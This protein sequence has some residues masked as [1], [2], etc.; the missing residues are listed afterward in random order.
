VEKPLPIP[1]F[2]KNRNV[3]RWSI[4]LV[5]VLIGFGSIV[6]SN[7]L[8]EKLKER[9]KKYVDLF[10]KTLEFT[11]NDISGT[12]LTFL[13]EEIVI[14]NETIPVI[15]A[16]SEGQ[17]IY[18]RNLPV[19]TSASDEKRQQYLMNQLSIMKDEHEPIII[20][21]RDR[22]G[23]VLEIQYIYYKNSYLLSQLQYYPYVQLSI[24]FAVGFLAYLSLSYS[25]SAEQNKV[26]VGLAKETAHQLGTPLSSL[27]AWLEY[28]RA[29]DDFQDEEFLKEIDKDI[30]R[31][32]MITARFSNI[33]SIPVVKSEDIYEAVRTSVNYLQK[34]LSDKVV[35]SIDALPND[36]RGQIN[37][38]LFDWVIEN[39]VKNAVDAMGGEGAIGIKIRRGKL[40]DVLLDIQ[41]E[42]KGIA[43][44]KLKEVFRPGYT[45][46]QRGWGLGLALAKRIIENYHRGKIF[47]KNSEIN[48][49]TT[50]RIILPTSQ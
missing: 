7:S 22:N 47:V 28:L 46:K 18:W 31:L 14:A 12:S 5:S 11:S 3:L 41:D 34:R 37:K 13:N 17:P 9:E 16:D 8:I 25:K 27:M 10:A 1:D 33:G 15:L 20:S 29:D 24:I 36:I 49:G 30:K 40:G 39:V 2:Y 19:D 50:F 42:G 38:P 21:I 6:F 43:K 26:W 23:R 4:I 45:T 32:E 44:T 35:F 48:Q